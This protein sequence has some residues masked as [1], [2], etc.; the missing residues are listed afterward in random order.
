MT[1]ITMSYTDFS[2]LFQEGFAPPDDDE[3]DEVAQGDQDEF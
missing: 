1:A 3:I 2:L